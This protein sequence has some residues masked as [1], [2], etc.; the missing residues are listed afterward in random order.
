M[1]LS[2]FCS[3]FFPDI[4]TKEEF[5]RKQRTETI[6]FSREKNPNTYECIVPANIEAVTAKVLIVLCIPSVGCLW[7]S[8]QCMFSSWIRDWPIH[9]ACSLS[10]PPSISD[11]YLCPLK[12]LLFVLLLF[13]FFSSSAT[14]FYILAHSLWWPTLTQQN[15]LSFSLLHPLFISFS[16]H[17]YTWIC[18]RI[19]DTSAWTKESIAW[20][21]YTRLYS[22]K[23]TMSKAEILY[24]VEC[25]WCTAWK[26]ENLMIFFLSQLVAVDVL[27]E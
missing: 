1:L 3:H 24:E 17:K 19:R 27:F 6:I 18:E 20:D 11:L 14:Y 10:C 9:S 13:L 26:K 8:L 25:F 21:T 12:W 16:Y 7:H 2:W 22:T 23:I 5:L 15:I 4:V